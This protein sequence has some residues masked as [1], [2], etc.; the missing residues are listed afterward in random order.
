MTLV[1]ISLVIGVF[2]LVIYSVRLVG[3]SSHCYYNY[4]DQVLSNAVVIFCLKKCSLGKNHF[5]SAMQHIVKHSKVASARN[6]I[7]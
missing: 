4:W 2:I 7:L 5:H 6:S 1:F 3:K